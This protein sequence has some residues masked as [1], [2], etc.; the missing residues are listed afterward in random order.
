MIKHPF[1]VRDAM[2]PHLLTFVKNTAEAFRFNGTTGIYAGIQP[3]II[4]D[5]GTWTEQSDWTDRTGYYV[6]YRIAPLDSGNK[7]IRAAADD[8]EA[9]WNRLFPAAKSRRREVAD[10]SDLS[11]RV[12]LVVHTGIHSIGD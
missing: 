11:T 7:T 1:T 12:T 5:A 6:T 4:E 2:N 3:F 9:K 8:A 10:P